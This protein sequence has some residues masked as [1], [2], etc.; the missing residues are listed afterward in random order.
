MKSIFCIIFLVTIQTSYCQWIL[1]NNLPNFANNDI[2]FYNQKGWIAGDYA[3]L[4]SDDFGETWTVNSFPNDYFYAIKPINENICFAVGGRNNDSAF[5]KKTIDGGTNW[6]NIYSSNMPELHTIY[7]PSDSIGYA[8]GGY[9]SI[10]GYILKT[11]NSGN[12]WEEIKNAESNFKSIF[13]IDPNKGWSLSHS[14]FAAN[15]IIWKTSN[16]GTNW[17]IDYSQ[18][19]LNSIFFIN[20]SVGWI[21]GGSWDGINAVAKVYKTTDGGQTWLEVFSDASCASFMDIQFLNSQQGW[22]IGRYGSIY[23]TTDGGTNWV[24]QESGTSW[25]L[26]SIYMENENTGWIVGYG[27]GTFLKTTNGGVTFINED[28]FLNEITDFELFQN[29]PNPFNPSTKIDYSIKQRSLVT[30]K[31]YNILGKEIATLVNEEKPVGNYEVEFKGNNLS[32]GVYF[33]K[34]QAGSFIDTK[35]FILIK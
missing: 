22:I 19:F 32:S 13:F 2:R 24:L 28:K 9:S 34:M 3:I 8:A 21:V 25:L 7:F 12:S 17:A 30:L 14:S 5:I 6:E 26:K 35:K 18:E 20:V 33:Y 29:Y 16:G 1:Q 10:S 27:G 11:T 23:Y 15:S 4:V 31:V